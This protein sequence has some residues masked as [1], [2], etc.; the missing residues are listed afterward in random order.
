MKKLIL[1]FI[2]ILLLL[3][4]CQKQEDKLV[5]ADMSAYENIGADH[6]FF[7]ITKEKAIELVQSGSGILYVG[8]PSCKNCQE[9][10]VKI[11]EVA[12]SE[13]ENVYY[14]DVT[15]YKI[16]SDEELD[17]FFDTVKYYF[18][19]SIK[20][21]LVV[22]VKDGTIK[23]FVYNNASKEDYQDLFNAYK[24]EE[25]TFEQYHTPIITLKKGI[26]ILPYTLGEEFN[27]DD[28]VEVKCFK[29][30]KKTLYFDLKDV[31]DD[32]SLVGLHEITIFASDKFDGVSSLDAT[33]LTESK[34]VIEKLSVDDK[35]P[36]VS[37]YSE[38]V[39]N[40]IKENESK[41]NNSG[42]TGSAGANSNTQS[43]V[44]TN[45][46]WAKS[47]VNNSAYYGFGCEA[48]AGVYHGFYGNEILGQNVTQVSSPEVGD[49]IAYFDGSGNYKHTATY[50]GGGVALHGNWS[51]GKATIA[52][53]NIYSSHVYFRL[54][55]STP[56]TNAIND[57]AHSKGGKAG[58]LEG[59][60]ISTNNSSSNTLTD[61]EREAIQKEVD[62]RVK[63][64]VTPFGELVTAASL[65]GE[66]T[67]DCSIYDPDDILHEACMEGTKYYN[68]GQ[69]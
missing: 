36:T 26:E 6:T 9:A 63:T 67:G 2:A 61:E 29:G 34:E 17:K 3:T 39:E 66:Q 8:R 68:P 13:N 32:Y 22:A 52:T 56:Y 18:E 21:P 31:D 49:L 65:R 62:E 16:G 5:K 40:T 41:T 12:T 20:I 44:S 30:E 1:V 54:G 60:I 27:L 42:S 58:W 10:V 37:S 50:L 28:Y 33:L 7:S 48:I 19:N 4:G 45:D 64:E 46:E 11:N 59:Y 51:N 57:L 69:E 55:G 24:S 53:E 14:L 38:Y 25:N 47:I 15:D 23:A 35:K 43:N